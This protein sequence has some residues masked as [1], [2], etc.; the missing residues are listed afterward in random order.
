[1]VWFGFV[2]EMVEVGMV[3][4]RVLVYLVVRKVEKMY[5]RMF[6]K[7]DL[8]MYEEWCLSDDF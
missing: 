5:V 1:M 7:E 3:W 4:V 8:W 2:K 6:R